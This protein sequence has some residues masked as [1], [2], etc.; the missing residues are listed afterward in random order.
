M[1]VSQCLDYYFISVLSVYG[2]QR[3][4]IFNFYVS[5]GMML[6]GMVESSLLFEDGT[7]TL[8]TDKVM[9]LCFYK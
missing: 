1:I 5:I 2:G 3:F 4:L 6:K 9:P 7:L 8:N